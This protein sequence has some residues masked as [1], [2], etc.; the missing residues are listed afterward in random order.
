MEDADVIVVG[1]GLAGLAATIHLQA[2]G[3][4]V[5]LVEAGDEAGGRVRTD[6]V[7][8]F[9][10]D[11]GFQVLLPAYPQVRRLFDLDRLQLQPFTRGVIAQGNE[12]SL[13]GI[14]GPARFAVQ[15]PG[16]ALAVAA[17]SLRALLV[18]GRQLRTAP[19]RS[20]ER[21]L[22]RWRISEQTVD[23]VFRPFLSGV[24]LDSELATSS[25]MF[26]L[27]WR[28]FLRGGAAV[29]AN[30][31][32][33]LPQALAALIADDALRLNT[34]VE[35][36]SQGHVDTSGGPLTARAVVV[37]TDGSTAA[38]LL[39]QLTEP[40]W[41]SVTTWYFAAPES[42]LRRPIL[43]LDGDLNTVVMSEVAPTYAPPGRALISA[44]IPTA[45]ENDVRPR[46][47]RLYGTSTSDWDLIAEY[48]I[49][50][51]LPR[52]ASEHP[53]TSPA[54]TAPGLYVAGDHRDTSS[55]QGA[56]AS[57]HRVAASVVKDLR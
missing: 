1:A 12:L 32:R 23:E 46:L 26:H 37:A 43:L 36:V 11:R 30:G 14:A 13:D 40:A 20:T 41:N 2:A 57:G 42:P 4:R 10:L 39:P 28:C 27:I 33:A 52:M 21:E 6:E 49:P 29:P 38:D 44:S 16:D 7:D 55:I 31:M 50:H 22:Q 8:G 48:R 54:K 51:A 47:Q 25:R 19:P 3:L 15:R 34:H 24:F 45:Q 56:L 53:F 35:S 18:P 9:L 5:V 17:L